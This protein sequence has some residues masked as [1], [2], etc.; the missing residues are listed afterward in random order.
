M[1]ANIFICENHKGAIACDVVDIDACHILLGRPFQY[2]AHI[3]GQRTH[4]PSLRLLV[5]LINLEFCSLLNAM[6][7][8]VLLLNKEVKKHPF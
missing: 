8:Y 2:D 1:Y 4:I 5:S 7:E 3:R 6:M